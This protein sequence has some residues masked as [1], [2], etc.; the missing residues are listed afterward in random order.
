LT[1]IK[2]HYHIKYQMCNTVENCEPEALQKTD[3]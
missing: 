1:S 3:F 2:A